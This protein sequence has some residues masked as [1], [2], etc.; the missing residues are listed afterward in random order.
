ENGQALDAIR[1]VGPGSHFLGCAH[2]QANFESAF[3]RSTIADN[4]SFEQWESEGGLD[5]A[6]RANK[7]WKRMLADYEAPPI[8]PG[9][10][11]ALQEFIAKKKAAEP[12]SYV[13]P[14]QGHRP[15]RP[16]AGSPRPG[17][18][19]ALGP[20]AQVLYALLL[21]AVRA[22]EDAA[23]RL[24][25]VADD[26]AAAM[27]ACRRQRVYGALET[28]EGVRFALQADLHGLVVFVSADFALGH[29]VILPIRMAR[30]SSRPSTP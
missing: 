9:V 26:A 17:P 23:V 27:G 11:E 20:V 3:Y 10:D 19:G 4:N 25:A 1:E 6:Q 13:Y 12:D 8:A 29:R 21:R 2:T 24:D 18:S 15:R 14:A 28:V 30:F 22:A 16:I 7:L 5:A